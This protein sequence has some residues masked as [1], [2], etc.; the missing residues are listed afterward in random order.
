MAIW[1][2]A[3]V[4]IQASKIKSGTVP[5]ALPADKGA[6]FEAAARRAL[7]AIKSTP[8]GAQMLTDIAGSGHVVT[9]Y[10]AW[11]IQTGNYQGGEDTIDSMVVPFDTEHADGS[12][13]LSVVLDR[14]CQDMSG[15]SKLKKMLG[16]GKAKPRYLNRDAL[17]RLVNLS[18]RDLQ[19]MESGRKAIDSAIEARLRAMLYDF[20][21][22]GPGSDCHVCFNHER[23]NLSQGHELHLPS[24]K[25]WK[26]R[27]VPVA[28]AHELI[29]AWRVV[30]GRVLYRYGWEEE[31]M[32]VGLPPFSTMPYT[33]NR[34]RIEFDS[35]GLAIRPDYQHL[36][37]AENFIDS[38]QAAIDPKTRAW[39]GNRSALEAKSPLRNDLASAM[40]KRRAAMGYD[41]DDGFG[42]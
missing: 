33:E 14:A 3:G 31:A 38:G 25:N 7:D 21:T 22:P 26:N 15:R 35:T 36:K 12:L 4:C 24:Y 30:V 16:I 18:P 27:P 23:L 42:G 41:D 13:E 2:N 29:H 17:G 39:Q 20:L 11:D 37:A 28:L 8:M 10:R 9:I 34:F 1:Y 40:G 32:T 19:A 5:K 6:E